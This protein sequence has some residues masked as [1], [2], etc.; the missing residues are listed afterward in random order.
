MLVT[1]G[2]EADLLEALDCKDNPY[3][4]ID[5]ILIEVP[6]EERDQRKEEYFVCDRIMAAKRYEEVKDIPLEMILRCIRSASLFSG[7]FER[8]KASTYFE[9]F[10]QIHSLKTQ[11]RRRIL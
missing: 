9:R 2:F 7:M 4:Q 1:K 11:R 3:A 10:E 5:K 6:K 8:A